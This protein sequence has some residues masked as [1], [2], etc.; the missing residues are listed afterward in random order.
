MS[1]TFD[2]NW[3]NSLFIDMVQ[4]YHVALEVFYLSSNWLLVKKIWIFL[5]LKHFWIM[6]YCFFN[7][8]NSESP[9]SVFFCK[10]IYTMPIFCCCQIWLS[11]FIGLE[12]I[13]S[14]YQCEK[15]TFVLF[16]IAMETFEIFYHVR[17]CCMTLIFQ[18]RSN[19]RLYCS[20]SVD[21]V[22][23]VTVSVEYA[24]IFYS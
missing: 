20:C 19:Y 9:V 1:L 24:L 10:E 23:C 4:L 12:F 8:T 18:H 22:E 7:I 14:I 15:V 13:L 6:R 3:L 2:I 21:A 5:I 17:H 16:F 11:F